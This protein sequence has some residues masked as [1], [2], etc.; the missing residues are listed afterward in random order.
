[1]ILNVV[2]PRQNSAHS[3]VKLLLK[4]V[5]SVAHDSDSRLKFVTSSDVSKHLS[6]ICENVVI[7]EPPT[8][9]ACEADILTRGT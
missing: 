1:M 2:D 6:Y 8:R 4:G 5:N 3:A 7:I 9:K